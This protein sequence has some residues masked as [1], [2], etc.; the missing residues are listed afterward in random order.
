MAFRGVDT[1]V[2]NEK[3]YDKVYR[4]LNLDMPNFYFS[5]QP[6]HYPKTIN[7]ISD[8]KTKDLYSK[9]LKAGF[10]YKDIEL[11][12]TQYKSKVS[13]AKKNNSN[14]EL[15]ELSKVYNYEHPEEHS[16][17]K[18]LES[19]PRRSIFWPT[20][21]WN[22]F[23]NQYHYWLKNIFLNGFGISIKDGKTAFQ[24]VKK[25]LTWTLSITLI[26]FFL[27][28]FLGIFIGIFLSKNENGKWQRMLSQIMYFLFSIP[29]FWFATLMV[30]Y[31]TTDDYGWWTNIFPSVAINIYPGKTTFQQIIMNA[32][33]LILPIMI[34]TLHSLAFI[35]RF[36]RRSVLDELNK[37][38]ALLAYSK[39]L[40]KHEVIKRHTLKNALIPLITVMAAAFANA[41][42]GS[43][44]LEVIFNIPGMGRLLISSMSSADWNVVFCITL[45]LSAVTIVSYI[46]ADLFYVYANP[47]IKLGKNN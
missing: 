6:N 37:P 8:P 26:D 45:L 2:E 7:Q 21:Q 15:I 44:V 27:S 16:S 25:A 30:V 9:L 36:V 34:L 42:A 14:N 3:I 24:K 38:Y 19:K 18:S 11:A 31:F 10:S 35:T 32:E 46:I 47:K 23:K 28:L 41:F 1:A 20:I 40:T 22:G 17:L 13:E 29:I 4:E 12:I 39:G 43:L 5:I 33:K